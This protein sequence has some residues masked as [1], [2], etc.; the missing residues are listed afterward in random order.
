MQAQ[1]LNLLLELRREWRRPDLL[2]AHEI[3]V[4]EHMATRLVVMYLGRAV[5]IGDTKTLFFAPKHPY[6]RALVGSV[7]T[8]NPDEYLPKVYLGTAY[9]NPIDPPSGFAFHPRCEFARDKCCA[10][11]L[12]LSKLADRHAS[13]CH[14]D[15]FEE[16]R[17][18][19][20][21]CLWIIMVRANQ[22][23]DKYKHILK[24][25]VLFKI[26]PVS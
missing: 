2:V 17:A 25:V 22:R 16:A 19:G 6:T 3:S 23:L 15:D 13:A 11:S 18:E 1:I 7:L 12:A 5:Q 8:P 10:V 21:K 9:L 24:A 26:S 20:W 14:L 4:V